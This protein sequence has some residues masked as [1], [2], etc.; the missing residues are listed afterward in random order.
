GKPSDP[1]QESDFRRLHWPI[2]HFFRH[3][4][5]SR[6]ECEELLQ[7]TFLQ[8]FKSYESFRSESEL[9][10]WVHGIAKNVLKRHFRDRRAAKRSAE[11][12]VPLDFSAEGEWPAAQGGSSAPFENPLQA[13]IDRQ[14]KLQVRAAVSELSD[15]QR[16]CVFL[17]L[18]Q[19]LR[20]REIADLQKI[21]LNRV[22]FLLFQARSHLKRRL[23]GV[24]M[25]SET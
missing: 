6:E 22:K 20:Y 25:G 2:F 21:P 13:T 7:E 1:M 18:D 10:T 9:D 17:R 11:K 4:G 19:D 23:E 15:E 12:V 8:A 14:T 5:L 3:W 24:L 16:R